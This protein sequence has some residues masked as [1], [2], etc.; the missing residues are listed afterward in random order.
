MK[1]LGELN[2]ALYLFSDIAEEVPEQGDALLNIADLYL[3]EFGD[4]FKAIEIVK[5]LLSSLSFKEDAILTELMASLY[6][7]D[8]SAES[9]TSR[10]KL[11]SKTSIQLD[12]SQ[13]QFSK[14]EKRK[15]ISLKPRV[16][17]ISPMFSVSPVFFLTHTFFKNISKQ[18]DLIFFNRGT[19]SDWATDAFK[20]IAKN[21]LDVAHLD[22]KTLAQKI[23]SEEIDVMYDL[24]GW[25]DPTALK[26]LSLKP[27]QQQ[28]KWVG[29]QSITTGLHCFDG[30][31]GDQWHTPLHLQNLYTE[32]LVNHANDYVIYTPPPYMPSPQEKKQ[33]VHAIFANPAKLSRGF[34]VA[35]RAIPGRKHFIHSKYRHQ[36][37]RDRIESIID[38]KDISYI[39]PETHLEALIALNQCEYLIDT[40]P[41]SSGLTAREAVALGVKIKTL[42]VGKLFCERHSARYQN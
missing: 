24:G 35:L 2:D 28:M 34:L 11:F 41:Y 7:R 6:D 3:N 15:K 10:V 20:L 37:V 38:T 36:V 16:G 14:T 19:R 25:M 40:F 5:P 4:P 22:P 1:E 9:L 18:C 31:I 39:Q 21:W 8:E 33:S 29:G 26:A 27:A 32:P 12:S 13:V 30:W 42:Q 17:L 23:Y